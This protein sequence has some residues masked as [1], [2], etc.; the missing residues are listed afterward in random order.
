MLVADSTGYQNF[1]ANSRAFIYFVLNNPIESI[2]KNSF[3]KSSVKS[4]IHFKIEIEQTN[5]ETD[6]KT[7]K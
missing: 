7:D 1:D 2:L 5:R 6:G 4:F 3:T